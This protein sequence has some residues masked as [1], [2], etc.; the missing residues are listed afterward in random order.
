MK[1][2]F[3]I[4]I[5]DQWVTAASFEAF[6]ESDTMG[7]RGGGHFAYYPEYVAHYLGRPDAALSLC[8]PVS[9]DMPK[10]D[11][12]P[13]FMLDILPSGAA[14]RNVLNDLGAS[15]D[16]PAA[17]WPTLLH[18]AGNPIGNIR[19]KEAAVDV[20]AEQHQGFE[21]QDIIARNENFIEYARAK[22]APVSGSSGAQGD[23]PKFLLVEDLEGR[24]HADR[25]IP[26]DRVSRHWIVKFPRGKKASDRQVL[27][28]EAVYYVVAGKLGLKVGS[29]L[30]YENDAL[31]IPRFDREVLNGAIYRNGVES[32]CA[33]AG[34]AEFGAHPSQ[35]SLL[36]TI[37]RYSTQPQEDVEEFILRDIINIAMGNTDNHPRNTAWLKKGGEARLA[38][39]F[40][41][42][43]M[44]LDE[45]GIARACRWDEHDHAG[46]P[47]WCAIVKS[48]DLP[49]IDNTRVLSRIG[50]FSKKVK[51]LPAVMASC[52]VDASI[53]KHLK[54]RIENIH[55]NLAQANFE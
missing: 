52:G 1:C 20:P 37:A 49:G 38:P 14:R 4:F 16:G 24:W 6:P 55:A 18:G 8:F 45:Q 39:L 35:N 42:A 48:L 12:W 34:I 46:N 7:Y 30:V 22:G 32:L 17:D 31:F 25:A 33:A 23:A 19:V 29:P 3:E 26:D 2:D 43:P 53:I 11:H 9:Y 36:E 15:M 5:D 28:N 21:R 51:T 13:A 40:D 54:P 50:Q 44:Y 27:K 47:D 10:M 41:F